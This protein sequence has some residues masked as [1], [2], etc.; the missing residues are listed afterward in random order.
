MSRRSTTRATLL[1]QPAG[2][3]Q[4]RLLGRDLRLDPD[5]LRLE[6]RDII[7]QL[8]DRQRVEIARLR[9]RSARFQVVEVH[10]RGSKSV[11]VSL[12]SPGR[13]Y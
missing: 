13:S 10:G 11:R 12:A 5:D 4:M 2:A 3:A 1:E 8:L 6:G 7:A 9:P